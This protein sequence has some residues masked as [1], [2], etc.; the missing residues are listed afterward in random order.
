M[1]FLKSK[2]NHSP[3]IRLNAAI[4]LA[5]LL[6]KYDTAKALEVLDAN[7]DISSAKYW[8]AKF[9]VHEARDELNS[10]LN[11]LMSGYALGDNR[12]CIFLAKL[13]ESFPNVSVSTDATFM[14]KLQKDADKLYES[15]S[16]ELIW[17]FII[18]AQLRS[19]NELLLG[20]LL[21][22]QLSL[23]EGHP[24]QDMGG[25]AMVNFIYD[26]MSHYLGEDLI[27][28]LKSATDDAQ[29]AKVEVQISEM[30]EKLDDEI[31]Q[32]YKV[33]VSDW[34]SQGIASSV[35]F[36]ASILDYFEQEL[37][38]KKFG[39]VQAIPGLN[40]VLDIVNAYYEIPEPF[41]G[42]SI[43]QIRENS[44][45]SLKERDLLL[46]ANAS[47]EPEQFGLTNRDLEL[48]ERDLESWGLMP[49]MDL[50]L[51]LSSSAGQAEA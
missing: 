38:E 32:A 28:F 8:R 27:S 25:S 22:L 30:F 43:Q 44:L 16:P 1:A 10:A 36:I 49:Y 41:E 37:D 47:T 24:A 33:G 14:E 15:R 17:A 5:L 18:L 26:R 34:Q 2:S 13:I 48:V 50:L 46:Y 45:R 4:D 42:F 51:D 3:N 6:I 20:N 21:S 39:S 11:S 19:D 31:T 23:M 12:C 7:V 35:L 29:I 40:F 9:M